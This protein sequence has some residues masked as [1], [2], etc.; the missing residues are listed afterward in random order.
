MK[1][2]F[3]SQGY[4]VMHVSNALLW[5]VEGH[6]TVTSNCYVLNLYSYIGLYRYAI[7]ASLCLIN[8]ALSIFWV[9]LVYAA[10]G[11]CVCYHLQVICVM[12][13][14]VCIVFNL[15]NSVQFLYLRASQ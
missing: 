7:H 10:L 12:M 6:L 2:M 14:T 4:V 1:G 13:W 9:R 11:S 8:C 3:S 15:N 5:G